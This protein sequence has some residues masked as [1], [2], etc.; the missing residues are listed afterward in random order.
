MQR[1]SHKSDQNQSN[2]QD[3]T[4]Y[5]VYEPRSFVPVLQTGYRGF[6]QLIKTP[7]YSQFK[8]MP[9]SIHRDPVWSTDTRKNKAELERAACYHCDQGGTPQTLSNE[10]GECI[11]EIEL[12]TWGKTQQVKAQHQDQILEQTNIRFQGQYYDE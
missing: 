10:K 5:Y 12:N 3:Y 8:S 11:W 7:D 6:I 9:Y 4:K 2:L 1:E